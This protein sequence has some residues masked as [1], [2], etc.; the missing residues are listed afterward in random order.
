MDNA[1]WLLRVLVAERRF[2]RL[3]APE[4]LKEVYVGFVMGLPSRK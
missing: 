2:R 1:A 4:L 3:D